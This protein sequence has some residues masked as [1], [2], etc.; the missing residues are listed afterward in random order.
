MRTRLVVAGVMAGSV[1]ALAAVTLTRLNGF[2]T[3]TEPSVMERASSR[4]A[5]RL[6]VPRDARNARNPIPFSDDVWADAR[7]H[8]ADHCALCRGNDGRGDT[9]IGRNLYPKAPDNLTGELKGD[10][11]RVSKIEMPKPQG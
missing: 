10:T 5:R 2:S 3:R 4:A 8:F 1:M 11:I 6:A 7:G 9:E